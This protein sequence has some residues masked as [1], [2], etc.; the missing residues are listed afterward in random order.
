MAEAEILSFSSG[1]EF[2]DSPRHASLL[3]VAGEVDDESL[4]SLHRLHDQL[5]H[6]RRTLWWGAGPQRD[7]APGAALTNS[8][9]PAAEVVAAWQELVSGEAPSE[10]DLL[11]N[12]PPEP[13]R[14]RGDHGQ[15][16]EGMMGGKPYGRPMPMTDDDIRDEL[17]LDS[18]TACFGPFL[19]QFPPPGLM[20]EIT[21]QGDVVQDAQVIRTVS[22]E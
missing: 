2:V 7:T 15:G 14:G 22:A 8:A 9:D 21:L 4:P 11:A 13:W 1:L 19:R 20:L 18:Y 10:P 6:P 3:L 17:A 16:G 5:P 12:E